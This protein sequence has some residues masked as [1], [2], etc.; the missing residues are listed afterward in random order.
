M[1]FYWEQI[2]NTSI[3]GEGISDQSGVSVGISADGA[4]VI[5]GARN[6]DGNGTDSGH[7]HINQDIDG[8]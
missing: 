5:I 7:A 2:G 8:T 1:P 4:R 3:N 6:N